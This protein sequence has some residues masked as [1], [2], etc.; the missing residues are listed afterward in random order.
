MVETVVYSRKGLDAFVNCTAAAS[1]TLRLMR[2]GG[3]QLCQQLREYYATLDPQLADLA[4]Q[5]KKRRARWSYICV[6]VCVYQCVS[7]ILTRL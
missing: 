5:I 4:K 7:N 1:N 6:C 2:A 3:T